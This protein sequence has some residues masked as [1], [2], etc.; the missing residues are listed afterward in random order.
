[1]NHGKF[2]GGSPNLTCC[3][4]PS[5]SKEECWGEFVNRCE[6]R[7]GDGVRGGNH[8]MNRA[9]SMKPSC[10]SKGSMQGLELPNAIPI[11]YELRAQHSNIV[12]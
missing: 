12:I 4:Q 8:N 3:L 11:T 2:G 7:K 6:V 10:L 9:G 1:M 5:N